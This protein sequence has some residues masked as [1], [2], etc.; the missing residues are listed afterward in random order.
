MKTALRVLLVEDSPDDAQ[1]IL[2]H[3]ERGGY[4]VAS[5]R[6][7]SADAMIKALE[8]HPWD[9]VICDYSMPHFSG[10]DALKLL[11]HKGSDAPFIFVSG[12][13]GEDTAVSALKLGAQDY[14]M[15]G[16]LERLIP[17]IQRELRELGERRERTRLENRLQQL[18][19]FEAIGR[20]AGGIAHD[21]N[22]VI[23]TV[24]G[25]AQLGFE[26][27]SSDPGVR[28]R[29]GKIRDEAQRA[30]GFTS[31]LLAFARRQ[32]LQPKCLS[33]NDAISGMTS[34]LQTA[35]GGHIEF[36]AVLAA[37]LGVVR[38]DPTQIDQVLMNLCLNARDAMPR[39]GRLVI[40]TRNTEL[41][42]DFCR[43]HS[44]GIPGK[45]VLLLVSDT[46]IGMDAATVE[47]IFEPFFTTKELG[48]GTGLGLATVYGIVKQ[49]EGFINVYSELG[50]GTTFH[51]Y[52][53]ASSGTPDRRDAL[54][55]SSI[56]KGDETILVADDHDGLREI[57]QEFLSACG[58]KI[59]LAKNG[60]EAVRIFR[61][62]QDKI[63]LAILDVTMPLM[64]GAEACSQMRAIR[65]EL[66]VILTTGHTA[67]S[68]FLG[69]SI[70][71]GAVFLQK[72]Y[73]PQELGQ[74]LR[75]VLDKKKPDR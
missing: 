11:R 39:G 13:I 58:Y 20:L 50:Q 29:F 46:G 35:L 42:E 72:P 56:S 27:A 43:V 60:Q 1:L 19:R 47:R 54:P 61:E 31:Q 2:R 73:A 71:S 74:T 52:F 48:R 44:Y 4:A 51:L 36:K 23:G 34:L 28:E 49:H 30:A 7:D 25:W 3:L 38:A 21:V 62:N 18:E 16:N 6:V 26:Q 75:S 68:S 57:A 9:L 12:T 15:K 53:P 66:P 24:L 55:V 59:I 37:D 8:R 22:N 10:T 67:E 64:G 65:P 70:E 41:N 32:V 69:P 63:D 40:E 33:L 45:Y 14:V 17:A 5:E